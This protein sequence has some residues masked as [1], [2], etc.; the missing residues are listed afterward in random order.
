[1]PDPICALVSLRLPPS[2]EAAFTSFYHQTY[3]PTLLRVVPEIEQV[4][5][6]EEFGVT[7]SLRWFNKQFWTLY[8][9]APGVSAEDFEAALNRP[10]REAEAAAWQDWAS[11]ALRDVRREAYR[12]S[13]AHPRQTWDGPF[14]SRP[15]FCVS[16]ETEPE[17]SEAF[18]KW[19]HHS[20]L[21]KIMAEVPAWAACR[22]YAS[23]TPGSTLVRTVYEVT[24]QLAF[25]EAF[26]AMRAP[27]RYASNAEWDAWVGDAIRWQDATCFRPIFR[28]PG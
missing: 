8:Q 16:V 1:M 7:G 11:R 22:R 14:G 27:H 12:V 5:R 18:D 2:D 24:H 20:Y 23:L 4:W 28:F 25:D 17:R 3:L 21:P 15:F 9:L 13:Y 26:A 6:F 19:Y 10:G